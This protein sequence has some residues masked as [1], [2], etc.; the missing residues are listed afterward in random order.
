MSDNLLKSLIAVIFLAAALTALLSMV[1]RFGR[2]G[3]EARAAR[4]R[5]VHKAAGYIYIALLAPLAFFGAKFLAEMGD[6]L[7][8]RG[9]LHFVLAMTLLAVLFLKFLMVK[10]HRL[11][12]KNAPALGMTLFSLTLII[13]LSTAG[14]YFLQTAAG[15]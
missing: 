3:D 14:F 2:P 9:T 7:S 1:A 13:F 10:T 6:G 15:K 8:V 4:L 11:L 5:K 12:L